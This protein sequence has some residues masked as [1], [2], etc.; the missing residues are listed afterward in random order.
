MAFDPNIPASVGTEKGLAEAISD[1]RREVRELRG[2]NSILGEYTDQATAR[3]YLQAGSIGVPVGTVQAI[4]VGDSGADDWNQ[5]S[6]ARRLEEEGDPVDPAG[7]INLG[8]LVAPRSG[9]YLVCGQV[10]WNATV[11]TGNTMRS[12]A[13]YV[14]G[15]F[16]SVQTCWAQATTAMAPVNQITSIEELAEGDV[17][18]L[19]ASHTYGG[20]VSV[21][22]GVPEFT[23]LAYHLIA[24][25]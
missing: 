4:P 22:G 21:L 18:N 17:I 9:K 8:N 5:V 2:V 12:G 1:L 19:A 3:A 13:V 10:F 20:T 7:S 6:L 15:A 23:W 11:A 24:V 25:V 16:R 14:N